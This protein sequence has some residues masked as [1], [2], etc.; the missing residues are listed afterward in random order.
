ME[1][2]TNQSSPVIL[3]T[4]ARGQIGTELVAALRNV[5]GRKQ[6]IATDLHDAAS[7]SESN[8]PYHQLNVLDKN[9]LENLVI[10]Y[11]VT[12]IYH[13]AAT[14]SAKGE[15]APLKAWHLNMQSLL[16]ILEVAKD[17]KLDKV[18]WPSSIAVFGPSTARKISPQD[19][20]LDPQTV[21]GISKEAGE[22]WCAYYRE[23]YGLDVRSIRYPGLISYSA[24]A[25]G[26]T[27][28]YAVAIFH[29]A[30]QNGSYNCYLNPDTALPMMY[31]D[32]AVRATL[33]LMDAPA[34][35]LKERGAYNIGALSFTPAELATE[36]Q[37]HLPGFTIS[38][39]ADKRQ[40]IAN[41]WPAGV[42][43]NAAKLDWNWTPKYDLVAM[44]TDMLLHL[45]PVYK[46]TNIAT[47]S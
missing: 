36:L 38:Y 40:S 35:V 4:G 37:K 44:T 8:R 21:Y 7:I 39:D 42:D 41:S 25:G 43:D 2:D 16:N 12:Q 5:Y 29:E 20:L 28:D 10:T 46:N 9:E 45:A 18:F 23:H 19:A 32:D 27:T 15:E 13:L 14:L 31:M 6:V 30:L 26:G 17:H 47:V 1:H 34:D 33:E 3:V 24:P 22:Q 11:G